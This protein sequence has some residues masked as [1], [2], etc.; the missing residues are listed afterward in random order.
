MA[1]PLC[2][3]HSRAC[4]E[5]FGT[6]R[7]DVF[8]AISVARVRAEQHVRRIINHGSRAYCGRNEAYRVARYC[9]IISIQV[10]VKREFPRVFT[11][12]VLWLGGGI[13]VLFL[14][15]IISVSTASIVRLLSGVLGIEPPK[16]AE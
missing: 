11:M 14:G 6:P 16:T 3:C 7:G 4:S 10:F 15:V 9:C 2:L 12:A 8:R 1:T 13:F 5:F